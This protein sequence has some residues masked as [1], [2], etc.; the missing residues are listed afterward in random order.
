M[1]SALGFELPCYSQKSLGSGLVPAS[2][3]ADDPEQNRPEDMKVQA[4]W[5]VAGVLDYMKVPSHRPPGR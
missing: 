4:Y 5:N 1:F 3:E 2:A